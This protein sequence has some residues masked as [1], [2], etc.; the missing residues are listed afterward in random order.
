MSRKKMKGERDL[1][2]GSEIWGWKVGRVIVMIIAPNGI[3]TPVNIWRLLGYVSPDTFE[4]GQHKRT[5]D[6]MITPGD[7]SKYI[8]E[9]DISLR[10]K[11]A[12]A[13]RNGI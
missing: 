8:R 11:P 6:G 10:T 3:K 1:I 2:I 7:I 5:S 13:K 12:K 9:N 4:C